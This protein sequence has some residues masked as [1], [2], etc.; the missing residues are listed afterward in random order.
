MGTHLCRQR[1]IEA[2]LQHGHKGGQG[3]RAQ[4]ALLPQLL[5]RRCRR[6]RLGPAQHPAAG[7]RHRGHVQQLGQRL[8]GAGRL[9]NPHQPQRYPLGCAAGRCAT[10]ADAPPDPVRGGSGTVLLFRTMQGKER[11]ALVLHLRSAAG[12]MRTWRQGGALAAL[13]VRCGRRRRAPAW[14]PG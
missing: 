7:P 4:T 3:S 11:P 1:A 6:C 8:P 14:R 5:R 10:V 12:G 13:W 2:G 9:C